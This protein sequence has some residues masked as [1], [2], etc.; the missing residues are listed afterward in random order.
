MPDGNRAG[1]A[2]HHA[3]MR[4]LLAERMALL[5]RALRLIR[6]ARGKPRFADTDESHFNLS[7]SA[8]YGAL[9]LSAV[10]VGV[11][12][13]YPRGADYRRLAQRL[14]PYEAGQLQHSAVMGAD[15]LSFARLWTAKEAYV[16]A[17]GSGLTNHAIDVR[18]TIDRYGRALGLACSDSSIAGRLA[19]S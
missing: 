2:R 11:D 14:F 16:K 8:S 13:E 7:H 12:I 18:L 19:T 9:A 17:V 15:K 10:P 6:D 5:P 1:A 3:M 4:V